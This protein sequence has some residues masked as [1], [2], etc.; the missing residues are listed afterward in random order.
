MLSLSSFCFILFLLTIPK[1]KRTKQTGSKTPEE[2]ISPDSNDALEEPDDDA[3]DEDSAYKHTDA[4]SNHSSDAGNVSGS[5]VSIG[6]ND[7]PG[8]V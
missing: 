1:A 6:S 7:D 3:L 2:D 5:D 8:E 4:N